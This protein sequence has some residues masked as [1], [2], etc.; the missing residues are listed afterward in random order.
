MS[1]QPTNGRTVDN[2][3]G[4]QAS[5][6]V[7]IAENIRALAAEAQL[8]ADVV[9]TQN[10]IATIQALDVN[11]SSLIQSNTQSLS[12]V[13]ST[14][15]TNSNNISTLQTNL[16]NAVTATNTET[17]RASGAES[18]LATR[19]SNSNTSIGIINTTLFN[20]KTLL[21]TDDVE[22]SS[23]PTLTLGGANALQTL[24]LANGSGI[25]T[26]NIS[27]NVS[28]GTCNINIGAAGDI[29]TFGGSLTNSIQL[30]FKVRIPHS[31]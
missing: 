9:A 23:G 7:V 14:V 8:G 15:T 24:N 4:S 12:G 25:S 27:N 26:V 2:I 31:H 21:T 30:S 3:D 18:N 13:Q 16:A 1:F 29:I 22:S 6:N 17:T 10:V 5:S 11:Q 28:P 20:N 19:V